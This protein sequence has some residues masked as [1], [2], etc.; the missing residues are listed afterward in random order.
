MQALSTACISFIGYTVV[1]IG[2]ALLARADI[3]AGSADF[4]VLGQFVLPLVLTFIAALMTNKAFML[5]HIGLFMASALSLFSYQRFV[6][7]DANW[8]YVLCAPVLPVAISFL[9]SK[10][11]KIKQAE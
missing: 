6:L 7:G 9:L 2:F 8:V 10:D 3:D 5:R 11:K 4:R 1:S